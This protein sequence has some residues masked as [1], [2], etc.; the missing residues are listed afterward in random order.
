MSIYEAIGTAW[1]IFTSAIAT[2]AILYL[3]FVGLKTV[4]NKPKDLRETDNVPVEV[5]EMFK[6]A[7]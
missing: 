5:K 7:R 1:V 3:A 6:I 4:S 2:V